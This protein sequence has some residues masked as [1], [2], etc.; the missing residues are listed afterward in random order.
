METPFITRPPTGQETER[1]RLAMSSFCDGS[2]QYVEPGGISRPGWR[3]F[4]R[5]IAEIIG[6][7]AVENKEVFDV[8]IPSETTTTDYGFSI[9]SKELSR[10]TAITDLE[11][12]GRVHMEVSNSPAKFWEPLYR[13]GVTEEA[14]KRQEQAQ[15]I[16]TTIL[17]TVAQWHVS[18]AQEYGRTRPNRTLD[19]ASSAY[20]TISYTKPRRGLDRYYQLHSFNLDF[21]EGIIWQ[22]TSDRCL[23]GLDPN[24]PS[25]ILVEWYG[26]SGGQLKYYPRASTCRYKSGQFMLAKPRRVSIAE[27]TA[28]YWPKEWV[29][30]GGRIESPLAR[31]AAQ[32]RSEAEAIGDTGIRNDLIEASQKIVVAQ[33]KLSRPKC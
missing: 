16:G 14:F 8:I 4:E 26:L 9:K 10:A 13:K 32:I 5:I 18:A 1:I 19:L 24:F 29:L 20:L 28:A 33:T 17:R 23:R 15:L 21:P 7:F 30:A 2:G 3:D 27:K 11:L 31:I 22:F 25:E 6:G 12:N